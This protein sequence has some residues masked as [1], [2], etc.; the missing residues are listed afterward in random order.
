MPLVVI[1]LYASNAESDIE[2]NDILTKSKAPYP[3][4]FIASLGELC[5]L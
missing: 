5:P 2:S 3:I 4:L 1:Y